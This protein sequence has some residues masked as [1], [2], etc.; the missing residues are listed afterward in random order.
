MVLVFLVLLATLVGCVSAV[1]NVWVWGAPTAIDR[2]QSLTGISCPTSTLC[3]ASDAGGGIVFSRD[4]SAGSAAWTRTVVDPA[5]VA[6]TAVSCASAGVCLAADATGNVFASTDPTSSAAGWI[7]QPIDP[8]RRLTGIACPST[9]LCVAT[10]DGQTILVTTAP[11]D[12]AS[13]WTH[14]TVPTGDVVYCEKYQ[15]GNCASGLIG[16]SCPSTGLCVAMDQVGDA[17]TTTAPASSGP[18]QSTPADPEASYA[19]TMTSISC[20]SVSLCMAASMISDEGLVDLT[21][22]PTAASPTWSSDQNDGAGWISCP[23][24]SL[25]LGRPG[26]VSDD[27]LAGAP[28]WRT[29]HVDPASTLTGTACPSPSE[30]LA[31]DQS[32][33]VVVGTRRASR[34]I[35]DPGPGSSASHGSDGR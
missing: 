16:V 21:A 7:E 15:L 18:W 20:P 6:L 9:T 22:N 31:V 34:R 19:G 29:V 2:G 30:C 25:C 17:L 35:P 33:D 32:G 5:G 14:T 23:L 3:V 26:T 8:G 11:T 10:D 4:P 13:G 24:T 27:P 28:S 1:A 12:G